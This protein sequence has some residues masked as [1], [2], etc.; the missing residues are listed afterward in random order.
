MTNKQQALDDFKTY[1]SHMSK[2]E[3]EQALIEALDRYADAD[4]ICSLLV[5]VVV[6]HVFDEKTTNSD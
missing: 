5:D 2:S 3:L 6:N 1:A 4:Q